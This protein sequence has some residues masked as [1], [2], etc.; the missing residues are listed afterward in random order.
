MVEI[1]RT[2]LE[3]CSFRLTIILCWA[4]CSEE[5]KETP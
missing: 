5:L 1:S 3:R 2:S 4:F